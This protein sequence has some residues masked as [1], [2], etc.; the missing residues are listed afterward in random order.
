MKRIIFTIAAMLFT[1]TIFA[2]TKTDTVV[3]TTT[4]ITTVSTDTTKHSDTTRTKK[5]RFKFSFSTDNH[6]TLK[7]P[8][9]QPGFSYGFAFSRIDIGFATLID[10]GSFKLSAD[11]Q[12][13]RYR[14]WKSS[15]FGLDL[16][17]IGYRFSS[18][19]KIY[20]SGGFDWTSYRLREDV[21]IKR[22]QPSLTYTTDDIDYEKNSFSSVYL[23][24][25][26]TFYWRSHNDNHGHRFH[27]AG[28]PLMGFLMNGATRQKSTENGEQKYTASFNLAKVQYGAFARIGYGGIGMFA[29]YYFND[30]FD[31]SPAQKGLKSFM[32]G[33]TIG[34]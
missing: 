25:P 30:M 33:A 7:T 16:V 15:N 31:D 22:F 14:S 26:L 27:L 34:F 23:R 19:F 28:G 1:A 5:R 18:S 17:Q 24:I 6:D 4:T 20:A 21:S 2:Q 32:I 8:S 11:N 12:F 29:K 9:K 10:N 3:T 13:L